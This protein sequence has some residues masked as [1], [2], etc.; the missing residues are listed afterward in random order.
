MLNQSNREGRKSK[1]DRDLIHKKKKETHTNKRW[2]LLIFW[3]CCCCCCCFFGDLESNQGSAKNKKEIELE[4]SQ[5]QSQQQ[6]SLESRKPQ[7]EQK[8]SPTK[9]QKMKLQH[10]TCEAF[11]FWRFSKDDP[12]KWRLAQQHAQLVARRI[13]MNTKFCKKSQ[14]FAEHNFDRTILSRQHKRLISFQ[15]SQPQLS[16]SSPL[17]CRQQCVLDHLLSIWT[18]TTQKGGQGDRKRPS[19]QSFGMF[20]L[21]LQQQQ[22]QHKQQQQQHKQQQTTTTTKQQQPNNNKPNNQT[23]KQQP[24]TKQPT[25][26][27]QTTTKLTSNQQDDQWTPMEFAKGR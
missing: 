19:N 1:S 9:F 15:V 24:N 25:K 4:S 18:H 6:Q 10:Q 3:S 23:T 8:L 17:H 20:L 12:N 5:T 13:K 22:Q 14:S 16:L 11:F 21:I 2:F 26:Q 7:T 27:H